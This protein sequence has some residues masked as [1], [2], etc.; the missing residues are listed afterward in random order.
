MI[1]NCV[2]IFL[3]LKRGVAFQVIAYQ[4]DGVINYIIGDRV[5]GCMP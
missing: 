2:K 4:T 5:R 1:C 3:H